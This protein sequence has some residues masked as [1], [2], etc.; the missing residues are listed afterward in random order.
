[1][2]GT[3]FKIGERDFIVPRLRVVA[4]EKAIQD[5]RA[6]DALASDDPIEKMDRVFAIV[7]DLLRPNYPDI[8]AAKAAFDA[9]PAITL[10][11]TAA[12]S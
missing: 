6:I 3:P 7:A 9:A 10:R 2:D 8:T 5:S 4:W 1:M 11:A 12:G